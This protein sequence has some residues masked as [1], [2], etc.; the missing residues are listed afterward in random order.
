LQ[1]DFTTPPRELRL[2]SLGHEIWKQPQPGPTVERDLTLAFPKEGVDLQF[3]LSWPG[4]TKAAARVRFTD[5]D[6]ETHEKI[7]WGEGASTE[8][9][10]FP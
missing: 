10:T 7:I 3:E 9:L 8:V 4:E 5:P 2:L 6:G 1:I